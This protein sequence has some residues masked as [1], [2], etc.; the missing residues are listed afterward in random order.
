MRIAQSFSLLPYPSSLLLATYS[1]R[2]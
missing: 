1:F 2:R